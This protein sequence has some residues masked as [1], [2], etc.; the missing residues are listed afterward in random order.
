MDVFDRTCFT[1]RSAGDR[2][3]AQMGCLDIGHPDVVEFV[4]AK[5]ESGRLRQFNLSILITAEFIQAVE[6]DAEWDLAFPASLDE[7]QAAQGGPDSSFR[8]IYRD[9]PTGFHYDEQGRCAMRVYC[10]IRARELWEL[11]MK[12]TYDYADP[13]F[14]LIDEVNRMNNLW[15][16]EDIR[17]TNP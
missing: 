9:F 1:I 14:I 6:Q 16:C 7:V 11:I 5:R 3:G 10:T 2:R 4:Q 13:G 17:A 15:F 8:L 12:S